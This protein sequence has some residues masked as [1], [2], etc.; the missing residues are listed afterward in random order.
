MQ[1]MHF[2]PRHQ[3]TVEHRDRLV[4]EAAVARLRLEARAEP[5][6]PSRPARAGRRP[7]SASRLHGAC[8][9]RCRD[10]RP[11]LPRYTLKRNSITSPSATS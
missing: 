6:R 2:T 8:D 9:R 11:P 7:R 10:P 3:A 5:P 4:A 1:P